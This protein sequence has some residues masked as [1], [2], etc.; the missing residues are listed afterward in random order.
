MMAFTE[1]L[2]IFFGLLGWAG[3]ILAIARVCE[4]TGLILASLWNRWSDHRKEL[5]SKV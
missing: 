4:A 1:T 2:G 3:L 5:A